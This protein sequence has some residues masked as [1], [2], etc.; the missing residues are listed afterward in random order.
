MKKQ[1]TERLVF[2]IHKHDATSLHYDFR[3]EI[4]GVMPS[5]AVPKGPSL[6]NTVKRL[7]MLTT[8]HAMEYRN[9]EGMLPEGSYGAGPV[10]IWD[11]GTYTPEIEVEKGVRKAIEDRGEGERAMKEGM[12]KGEIKFILHGKRLKGSF[13]LV[14]TKNFGRKNA[15][16]FIK[17]NDAF[18]VKGYDAHKEETSVRSKKTL[19]EIQAKK[20]E[21]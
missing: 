13:A 5:W 15:W 1:K 12:K 18:V 19:Q 21:K 9:F 6:D 3:L 14:K 8:D 20:P 16:L 2:V 4:G 10:I 17:H 11:E 7:A